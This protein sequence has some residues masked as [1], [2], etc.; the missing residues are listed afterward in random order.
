VPSNCTENSATSF[1]PFRLFPKARL[2]E[3]NGA[4]VHIGAER[5]TFSSYSRNVPAT[6]STKE[7]WSSMFGP[8]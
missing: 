7:S 5:S 8:T 6:S 2:L 4:P 3:K 1:G